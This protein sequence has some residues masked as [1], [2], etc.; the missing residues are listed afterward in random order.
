MEDVQ[1]Q[2]RNIDVFCKVLVKKIV[3]NENGLENDIPVE[4]IEN[5]LRKKYIVEDD[6]EVSPLTKHLI[7]LSHVEEPLVGWPRDMRERVPKA[8][9]TS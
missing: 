9:A 5:L 4:P 6:S 7:P 1:E 3:E 2:L 8:R